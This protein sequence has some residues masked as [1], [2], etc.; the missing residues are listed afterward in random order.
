[1]ELVLVTNILMV[2]ITDTWRGATNCM[3]ETT[4]SPICNQSE[5]KDIFW[6]HSEPV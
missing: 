2:K 4:Y 3:E 5:V 6:E 1:M